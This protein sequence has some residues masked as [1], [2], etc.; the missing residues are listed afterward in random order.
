[1]RFDILPHV[2]DNQQVVKLYR[3]EHSS[4]KAKAAW[5]HMLH[6][7]SGKEESW[8]TIST[9]IVTTLRTARTVR[10]RTARIRITRRTIRTRITTRTRTT[11]KTTTKTS[12]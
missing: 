7:G 2:T 9:T 3:D 8:I 11:R 6:E 5:R 4:L 10:A 1:M 12:G